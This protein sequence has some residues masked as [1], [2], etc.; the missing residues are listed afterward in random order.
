MRPTKC[1]NTSPISSVAIV[2]H[3]SKAHFA[4]LPVLPQTC[5]QIRRF[6]SNGTIK[7]SVGNCVTGGQ[8]RRVTAQ[9]QVHHQFIRGLVAVEN[10]PMPFH[11]FDSGIKSW[12]TLSKRRLNNSKAPV[13]CEALL[14]YL[15]HYCWYELLHGTCTWKAFDCGSCLS[16]QIDGDSV[17]FSQ[18]AKKVRR[19]SSYAPLAVPHLQY[20]TIVPLLQYHSCSTPLAVPTCTFPLVPGPPAS[21]CSGYVLSST[22]LVFE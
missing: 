16:R 3:R 18:V 10:L 5:L 20:P 21:L 11:V 2:G 19:P 15:Q 22:V 6:S 8:R 1:I 9:A 13:T 17:I 7:H 4:F 14:A 12:F